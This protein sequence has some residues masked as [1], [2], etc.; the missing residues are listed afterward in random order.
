VLLPVAFV[1]GWLFLRYGMA[2]AISGHIT[3]NSLLLL[4]AYLASKIPDPV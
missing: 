1:L 4:L 2:G 3:Y